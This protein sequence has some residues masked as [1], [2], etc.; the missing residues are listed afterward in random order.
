MTRQ[1][2]DG[3]RIAVLAADG[4]EQVELTRPMKALTKH[5]AEVDIVSL[6]RGS[7]QG[8]NHL[9]PGRKIDVDRT[10]SAAD[11][12]DYHGLHIPGGCIN[13]DLL[14]QSED[15]LDFVRAID[16]ARKP[17]SVICHGPWV[18]ISA[19]LVRGRRLA[20]W[21]GIKDDV[22][23][24]GAEWVDEKVVVDANW[25]SSRSPHD[26]PAFDRAI[27]A[28]FAESMGRS[29]PSRISEMGVGRFLV[30][31]AAA[32]AAGFAVQQ[33]VRGLRDG[34]GASRSPT[35]RRP[36]RQRRREP[37]EFVSRS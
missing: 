35:G 11:P 36:G 21:P 12:D 30:G 9:F 34:N 15:A 20:A 13:P 18:L 16:A 3:M 6:K 22:R 1:V 5:G 27:V 7:I 26:L 4:F 28:H 17:I 23:N 32:A 14:R 8:L 33:T 31:A 25:V 19:G 10:I 24:A 29:A 37:A 2:L